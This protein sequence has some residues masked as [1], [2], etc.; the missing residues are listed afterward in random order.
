VRRFSRSRRRFKPL[1]W[2][3]SPVIHIVQY[4]GFPKALNAIRVV[5]DQL[6]ELGLDIPPA[7]GRGA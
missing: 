1:R 4:C 2:C 7:T 6:A 3:L 5:T